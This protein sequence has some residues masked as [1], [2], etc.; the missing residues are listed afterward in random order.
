MS[1]MCKRKE[2]EANDGSY[3]GPV[4]AAFDAMEDWPTTNLRRGKLI[5]KQISGILTADEKAELA[6]LQDYADKHLA[7]F[8]APMLDALKQLEQPQQ[9][10][11]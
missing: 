2:V 7:P 6:T 9:E 8:N 3:G 5:D 1:A 11:N 4:L 10:Q